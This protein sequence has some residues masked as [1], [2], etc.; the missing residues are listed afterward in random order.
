MERAALTASCRDTDIIEKVPNAGEI[1]EHDG[2]RCQVMHNGV[3]VP[4]G[5]YHGD[6]MTQIIRDLRGH[7]EP[8]EEMVFHEVM[9]RLAPQGTMLELGCFWAYYS[10]WFLHGFSERRS[11]LVEPNEDKLAMGK[12]TFAL[13]GAQGDFSL[14]YVGSAQSVQ[15]PFVDWD[16]TVRDVPLVVVDRYTRDKGIDRLDVL[17]ADVQGAEAHMLRGAQN[18]LTSHR[19]DFVFVSTHPGGQREKGGIHGE[20]LE[21]LRGHGYEILTAHTP[22]QSFSV[23]G[24]IVARGRHAPAMQPVKVSIR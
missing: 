2:Q 9:S 7:H 13:N 19:I 8:Q 21:I 6:W 18:L 22:R 4:E 12:R 24:L 1:I 23:D 11:F 5:G 3:L 20:C 15:K 14:G 16:G 17:H 10:A